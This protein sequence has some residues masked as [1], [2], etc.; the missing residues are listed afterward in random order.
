MTSLPGNEPDRRPGPAEAG[1]TAPVTPERW[2]SAGEMAEHG[3]HRFFYRDEGAASDALALLHGFPTA[4]WDWHRVWPRLRGRFRLIAPD[5]LGFGF[6][7][8]PRRGRYSIMEQASLVE[9]LLRNLGISEVSL[10]VHDYGGTVAQELLAR[11]EEREAGAEEPEA[12]DASVPRIRSICFLNGGLFPEAQRPR[13]IQRLLLT[14][15]G[16]LL[17]RLYTERAFARS[18]GP[19]FGPR[20]RPTERELADYW[21]LVT[22]GGGRRVVHRL[23]RYLRER[24][25]HRERWVG[26]MRRTR[27]PLRLIDGTADPVSGMSVVRRYRELVPDADLVLLDGIG[28]YPQMEDPESV[29]REYLAFAERA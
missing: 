13:L 12:R 1:G 11:A 25:A 4:S 10:L 21:S 26:A 14:P 5:F 16:P 3:G 27:I 17:A 29:A 7:S 20:T 23:A 28:H 19:I 22:H 15:L 2:R 24:E 8:K 6:S 9:T 18:F